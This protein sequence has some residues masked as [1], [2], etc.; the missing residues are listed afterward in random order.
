VDSSTGVAGNNIPDVGTAYNQ[1][2]L[3]NIHASFTAK[4]NALI[5]AIK[6]QGLMAP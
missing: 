6:R 2:T 5:A 3:N 1:A 4:V